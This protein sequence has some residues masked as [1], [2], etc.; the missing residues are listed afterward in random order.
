MAQPQR[1]PAVHLQGTWTLLRNGNKMGLYI[2]AAAGG[3]PVLTHQRNPPG[4]ALGILL[5]QKT[6]ND[7]CSKGVESLTEFKAMPQFS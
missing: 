4:L 5:S 7:Y 3:Q 6:A 2:C 1:E